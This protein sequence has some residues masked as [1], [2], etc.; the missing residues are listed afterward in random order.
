MIVS[1]FEG[2]P[3]EQITVYSN[4][5]MQCDFTKRFLDLN[6]ELLQWTLCKIAGLARVQRLPIALVVVA[7]GIEPFFGFRPGMLEKLT[8]LIIKARLVQEL[9]TGGSLSLFEELFG[10]MGWTL[11]VLLGKNSE[12][13]WS[14]P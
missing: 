4:Q 8:R 7:D 14:E 5:S 1:K 2:D 10:V 12:K 3:H 6:P 13:Y 11:T 9:E